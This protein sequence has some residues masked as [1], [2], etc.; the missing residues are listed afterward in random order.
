MRHQSL[1][2]ATTP[3]PEYPTLAET[4]AV[5]VAVV[6]AGIVGIVAAALLAESGRS[7]ALVEAGRVAAGTSGHTTAKLTSQHGVRYVGLVDRFGEEKARSYALAQEA[8]MAWVAERGID[9]DLTEA[10]A[11]VWGA[12][13][14]ERKELREEA[15]VARRLGLPAS[16]VD[17]VPLPVPSLGALRYE[18]Q[19]QFHPRKLLLALVETVAAAGGHVFERSR[20]SGVREGDPCKVRTAEGEIRAQAVIVATQMPFT[21]RGLIFTK[22]FPYRGYVVAFPIQ[23]EQAPAGMFINAGSPTRS[24]RTAPVADGGR[25]LIVSGEGHE[26]GGE[27]DTERRYAT[28]ERWAQAVFGVGSAEYRWSAQDY[29]SVDG[30]P[31]VGRLHPFTGRIYIAAGFG[32]WGMTNGI[33]AGMLLAALAR[34]EE[35]EW[36]S[37][38]EPHR[39][40]T[41]LSTR[42]ATANAKSGA[43]LL[44]DR[45]RV[46]SKDAVKSLSPG[47][48]VVV[49]SG[50]GAVAVHRRDDGSLVAVSARCTH[51]GCL[52][53]WNQGERSWDCPCH[54]SRFTA[55]GEVLNGPAVTALPRR[56]LP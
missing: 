26:V 31:F 21:D 51:L 53:R 37:V 38:F 40:Q 48:G 12:T 6:G 35:H 15:E 3:E 8:A 43:R 49:R 5:D 52:V 47:G 45:A 16:F 24:V 22:A 36:S 4:V 11:Y 7:V 41:V 30:M 39:L 1:W 27:R 28:L 29:Y 25:L 2:L 17:D 23:A 50:L 32:G 46:S 56:P 54:G 18:R 20:A 34:G 14:S 44:L 9:C 42:Y 10:A 33:V 55:E 19:L 13:A